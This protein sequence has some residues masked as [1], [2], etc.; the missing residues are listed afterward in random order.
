MM[1][2]ATI[3]LVCVLLTTSVISGTFAKYIN[4]ANS[5]DQ[6]SRIVLFA[7]FFAFGFYGNLIQFVVLGHHF[8]VERELCFGA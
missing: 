6:H 1:R 4:S 3:L 7:I 8:H 5:E 2:L